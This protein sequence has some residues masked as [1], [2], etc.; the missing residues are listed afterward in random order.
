[1]L[2]THRK[3]KLDFLVAKHMIQIKQAAEHICELVRTLNRKKIKT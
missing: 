2:L 3:T 1:M